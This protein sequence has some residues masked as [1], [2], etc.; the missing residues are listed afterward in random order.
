[1][2]LFSDLIK[3]LNNLLK[4]RAGSDLYDVFHSRERDFWKEMV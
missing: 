1:M 2:Q 3:H 4:T